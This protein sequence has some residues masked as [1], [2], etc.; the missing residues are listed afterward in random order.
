MIVNRQRVD[1]GIHQRFEAAIRDLLDR[2]DAVATINATSATIYLNG[3]D[4]LTT[5]LE[6]AATAARAHRSQGPSTSA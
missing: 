4:D 1:A 5:A 3:S 2:D 6:A